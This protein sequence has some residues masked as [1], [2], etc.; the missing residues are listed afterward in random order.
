MR[1]LAAAHMRSHGSPRATRGPHLHRHGRS[2]RFMPRVAGKR[3]DE[4]AARLRRHKQSRVRRGR[5]NLA[6]V[7]QCAGHERTE[8]GHRGAG[9]NAPVGGAE[10]QQISTFATSAAGRSTTFC[11]SIRRPTL[12]P[13]VRPPPTLRQLQFAVRHVLAVVPVVGVDMFEMLDMRGGGSDGTLM[14]RLGIDARCE[15][16]VR[17]VDVEAADNG[18][19][20]S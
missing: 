16:R 14:A 10:Q 1:R 9:L 4:R 6:V 20:P 15:A 17:R 7:G 13:P 11:T 12:S 5:E 3:L 18:L 2:P 8:I 19:A